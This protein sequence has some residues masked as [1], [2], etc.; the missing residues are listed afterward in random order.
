MRVFVVAGKAGSGKGEVA[1]LINE[2]YIYKLENC[3][4]TQ[5]S[6]YLK[7]FAQELTDWDGISE[8]K[9]RAFLQDFGN[10]IRAYDK[11]FFTKRMI[12]DINI[13]NQN[14][15]ENIIISDAR[16][17]EEIDELRENFDNVYSIYVVNQFAPSKLS[18]AEQAHITETALENY[19]D[20]DKT[21]AND[22]LDDLKN[23]VFT[24]LEGIK[25]WKIL[26][27]VI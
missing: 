4:V 17:P 14:G 23:K 18:V 5:Y 6:K 11:Y 3:V 20:F 27:I 12:E 8:N 10:K 26:R 1:K 7:L 21:I 19:D 25:W 2:Y 13:Y 24:F 22:N 15:I 16:M 9:P